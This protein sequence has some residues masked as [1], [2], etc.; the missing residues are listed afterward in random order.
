MNPLTSILLIANP[1]VTA[2]LASVV[3]LESRKQRNLLVAVEKAVTQSSRNVIEAVERQKEGFDAIAQSLKSISED[4]G[5]SVETFTGISNALSTTSKTNEQSLKNVVG[6]LDAATLKTEATMAGLSQLIEKSNNDLKEGLKTAYGEAS[7]AIT[8]VGDKIGD[9]YTKLA[10]QL[11]VHQKN[12]TDA[13]EKTITS[14]KELNAVLV[15]SLGEDTKAVKQV[16]EEATSKTGVTILGLN[17]TIEKSNNDLKQ[18]L[19]TAYSEASTA[20]TSVGDKISDEYT[21]LADRLSVH[22]KNTAD[23]FEKAV[24]SQQSLNASLAKSINE[25]TKA[26]KE[27]IAANSNELAAIE[28]TLKKAVSI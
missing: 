7:T 17:Q 8:S 28:S 16:I 23:A 22:E 6:A 20:I 12:T 21:K 25:D 14:Q 2:L 13:F 1:L 27:G 4:Q 15:K 9:E 18:D 10:D 26:L 11:F 24:T 5:R 19:K 3:F